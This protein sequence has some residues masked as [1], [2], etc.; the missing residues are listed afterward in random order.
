MPKTR[1][2]PNSAGQHL[3]HGGVKQA[4]GRHGDGKT[5]HGQDFAYKA[6][7]EAHEAIAAHQQQNEDVHCGHEKR[8]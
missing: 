1:M 6:A 4:H 8:G 2:N 3:R 7:P 5:D